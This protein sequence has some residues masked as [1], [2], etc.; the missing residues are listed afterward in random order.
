MGSGMLKCN[1]R[2]GF[3]IFLV[4]DGRQW[5]RFGNI[6]PELSTGDQVGVPWSTAELNPAWPFLFIPDDGPMFRPNVQVQSNKAA[7]TERTKKTQ[8]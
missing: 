8:L 2:G 1:L 6:W 7:T 3:G 5:D 4:V